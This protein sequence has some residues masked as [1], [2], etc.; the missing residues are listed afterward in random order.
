M[1]NLGEALER[2][3]QRHH[4]ALTA[5][6]RSLTERAR[7]AAMPAEA[8]APEVAPPRLNRARQ[9]QQQRRERRLAR[10]EAVLDLHRQGLAVRA[11][12]HQLHIGRRHVRQYLA[13]PDVFD[14]V[15]SQSGDALGDGLPE[16]GGA[17]G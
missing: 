14:A 2:L 8:A 15:R 16:R 17:L 4:P 7:Q 12:A 1:K 6:A 13:A 5:A 3:L 11:I 9:E 10:Y